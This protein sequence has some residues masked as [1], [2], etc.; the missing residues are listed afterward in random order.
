M[1]S[2]SAERETTPPDQEAPGEGRE[3]SDA[4]LPAV[5]PPSPLKRVD[6]GPVPLSDDEAAPAV[7]TVVIRDVEGR[8]SPARPPRGRGGSLLVMCTLKVASS[9][10]LRP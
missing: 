9:C 4:T 1:T 10:P 8:S 7:C 5:A 2:P 6:E 3:L